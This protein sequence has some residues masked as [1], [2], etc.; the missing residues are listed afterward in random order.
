MD[1][2]DRTQNAITQQSDSPAKARSWR[3]L[4]ILKAL[5]P[6]CKPPE[7]ADDSCDNVTYPVN[8]VLDLKV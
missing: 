2:M 6:E 4:G 7:G 1:N 8:N 5:T 3:K